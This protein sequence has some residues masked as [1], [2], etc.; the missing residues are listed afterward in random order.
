MILHADEL[1]P[2]VFLGTALHHDELIGPHAGG[3]D[4][5]DFSGFDEVVEGFHGF[6]DG[7]GGVE[8]VDLEQVDVG[9]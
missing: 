7:G 8:A 3:A 5:A 4:V 9:C 2:A 6:F 1:D